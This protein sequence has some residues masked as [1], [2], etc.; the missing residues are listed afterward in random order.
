MRFYTVQKMTKPTESWIT[1]KLLTS[2][3]KVRL[4]QVKSTVE[5][6]AGNKK[7]ITE[8]S[9]TIARLNRNRPEKDH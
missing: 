5:K 3:V 2:A 6:E 1:N 4:Q 7:V 9:K 8:D